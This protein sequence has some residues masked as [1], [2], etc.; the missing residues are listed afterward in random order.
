[1]SDTRPMTPEQ[2]ATLKRL[3]TLAAAVSPERYITLGFEIKVGKAEASGAQVVVT[4]IHPGRTEKVTAAIAADY[5]AATVA[6]FSS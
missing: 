5:P 1:M 6:G 4:D 2:A 3:A